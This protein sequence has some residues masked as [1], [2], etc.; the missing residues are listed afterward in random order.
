MTK[1]INSKYSVADN[2]YNQLLEFFIALLAHEKLI[3]ID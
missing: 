2:L 3:I 1:F